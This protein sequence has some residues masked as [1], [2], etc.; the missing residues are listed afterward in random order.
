MHK[1]TIQIEF[2][3]RNCSYEALFA[4]YFRARGK[5][6]LPAAHVVV[7]DPYIRSPHQVANFLRLCE[8]VV[9]CAAPCGVS[10]ELETTRDPDAGRAKDQ[11][12]ELKEIASSLA[13]QKPECSL[14]V[15]FSDT[16]HDRRIVLSNGITIK[17]GRG[18]DF[19][20]SPGTKPKLWIGRF[21]WDLRPCL[22]TTID[23]F[24]TDT[25]K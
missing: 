18:L 6:G 10:I 22:E 1:R 4:E 14:E 21:D 8:L 7:E 9:K 5:D 11:E 17:I 19:Y 25:P 15:R 16:L 2:G 24:D 20:Q 3:Q 23:I 13:E 12:A